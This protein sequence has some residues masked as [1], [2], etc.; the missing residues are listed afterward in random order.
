[1]ASRSVLVLALL[2]IALPAQ[3][4]TADEEL[5]AFARS[6]T[7]RQAFGLR[8]AKKKVGWTLVDARIA[9]LDGRRTFRIQIETRM[10]MSLFGKTNEMTGTQT[11]WYALDGRGP[12]VKMSADELEDGVR[13]FEELTREGGG[14]VVRTRSG[15]R[16]RSRPVDAPKDDLRQA[17]GV[18]AWLAS[19]PKPGS[20]MKYWATD[21]D[22]DQINQQEGIE[23]K[24][25]STL[26]RGGRSTPVFD[27]RINFSGMKMNARLTNLLFPLSMSMGTF[28]EMRAQPESVAK[29][30]AGVADLTLDW[31]IVVTDM[32]HGPEDLLRVELAVDGL[33]EF[34]VPQT[35]RQRLASRATGRVLTLTKDARVTVAT[36]LSTE[37]RE[38]WL[39][40][41]VG[42]ECDHA[43]IKAHASK[44]VGDESDA[45]R[46]AALL[47]H[48]VY[49]ALQY[50]VA[51]NSESALTILD[52]RAGDCSEHARLFVALARA[53]GL[54]AREVGG[55]L[56]VKDVKPLFAWHA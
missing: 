46:K 25:T 21:L 26:V 24:G 20:K 56:Y 41:E 1:M 40:P 15:D 10:R 28:V 13:T 23:F 14:W 54:P 48:W 3:T 42:I 18:N 50:N 7:F 29:D 49:E 34:K 47:Q 19:G 52:N 39:A 38:R 55:L 51:R 45:V 8:V 43:D 11:I 12:V 2:A 35:H 22:K 6:S 30:M 33:G 37:G 53:A 31:S 16:R 5:V 4:S 17:M 44:I 9:E 36:P 27:V 32:G